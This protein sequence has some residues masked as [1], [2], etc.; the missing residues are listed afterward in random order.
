LAEYRK[1]QADPCSFTLD[2]DIAK[3]YGLSYNGRA[4]CAPATVIAAGPPYV[5]AA[6]Y[7][8]AV[9]L[10]NSYGK[11]AQAQPDFAAH[12]VRTQVDV[13]EML[14]IAVGAGAAAAAAAG[15]S[16]AVFFST[17]FPFALGALAPEIT[18]FAALGLG[19][20]VG[21]GA[22]L[23]A[24]VIAGPAAIVFICVVVGVIAAFQVFNNKQQ[25]DELNNLNNLLSQAQ[26]SAPDL[27][28]FLSDSSGLGKLKLTQSLVS[29]TMPDVPSAAA[30]PARKAEDP[31]FAVVPNAGQLIQSSFTYDDWNGIAWRAETSGGWFKQTC[32]GDASGQNCPPGPQND[33]F[34]AS[35]QYVDWSGV[36]RIASRLGASFVIIKSEPAASDQSC[37]ADPRTG[38]TPGTDF[39][40]CSGY[41]ARQL[42]YTYRGTNY[43]MRLS[44]SPAFTSATTIYFTW[45]G[46]PQEALVT[47]VG[48]P[49]PNIRLIGAL[50]AGVSLTASN[51]EGN[52][53]A[54]FHFAG[55]SSGALGTYRVTLA[56]DPVNPND[57]ALRQ[58]FTIV[59][60]SQLQ[61]TSPGSLAVVYGQPV[62]FLVT[63]TGALPMTLSIDPRVLPPGLSFHDN[64]NGT[65]TVNGSS[66]APV[67][68]TY[69][70]CTLDGQCAGI[71]ATNAQGSVTQPFAVSIQGPPEPQITVP[72]TNFIAGI[73]NSFKVITTGATSAVAFKFSREYYNA[74]DLSWLNFHNNGDGT[75]TLS[76]RPPAGTSGSFQVYLYAYAD[77]NRAVDFFPFDSPFRIDVVGQP[78][79]LSSNRARFTVGE[80]SSFSI[81][82]N[83]PAGPLS[84]GGTLP[85]GLEFTDHGNGTA[86]I[87]GIPAAGAGGPW[88]VQLSVAA[89]AGGTGTQELTLQVE[90]APRFTTPGKANFYAG[91]NSSF[92]VV[93]SGY[94]ALSSAP[95][96]QGQNAADFVAGMQFTV[97]GLPADLSYSNLNPEGYNTGTLMLS[98]TPSSSDVGPHVITISADN[99]V[100]APV[101]QTLILNIASVV[102]DVNGDGGV[103]CTDLN[104]IKASLN[105]YRGQAGYNAAA[106]INNDGVINVQDLA[107]AARDV[108]KGT[109]CR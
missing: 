3:Q 106:D 28:A 97:S 95:V 35:I 104:L 42:T 17:I 8:T 24:G 34:I 79:F 63:T 26:N 14:G 109:V 52:G 31:W 25:L 13:A 48:L 87:S 2:P 93:V 44:Q 32:L 50:P 94:P 75:A 18:A 40:G 91:Q 89:A 58:T 68:V 60:A 67:G 107:L 73:S 9:G 39:S 103:N 101:T 46:P 74:G 71:T 33:S 51:V 38:V 5:P 90:E 12:V 66:T 16:I 45:Q 21:G 78:V 53:R 23:T 64:G 98:G 54:R 4:L 81:S 10:K 105:K 100:G 77:V 83:Q 36:K 65:A 29:Q 82:T 61:V 80:P 15:I 72:A 30:L 47:A 86:T 57:E 6:S 56:A 27:N 76:G 88:T 20:S 99:G 37:P 62:S 43:V 1:W 41:V 59:I 108:L 22:A 70:F 85:P 11:S 96:S 92:Q 69:H 102:G 55:H 19:M 7:F 84:E 49:A